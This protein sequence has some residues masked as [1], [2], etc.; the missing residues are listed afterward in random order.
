MKRKEEKAGVVGSNPHALT[1]PSKEPRPQTGRVCPAGIRG[2]VIKFEIS[3]E[4]NRMGS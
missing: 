2:E 3:L 1:A 4:T